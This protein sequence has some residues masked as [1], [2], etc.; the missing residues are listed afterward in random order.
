MYGVLYN[1][2]LVGMV[3]LVDLDQNWDWDKDWDRDWDYDWDWG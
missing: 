3:G 2:G 1:M